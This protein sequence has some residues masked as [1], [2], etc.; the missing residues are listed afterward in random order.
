[1]GP[2]VRLRKTPR[3]GSGEGSLGRRRQKLRD[4]KGVAVML[5]RR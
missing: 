4:Q 3:A 2:C 5:E 1:M